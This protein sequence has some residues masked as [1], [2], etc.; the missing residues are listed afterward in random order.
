MAAFQ[1]HPLHKACS[2]GD[3]SRVAEL[4]HRKGQ[5]WKRWDEI[6]GGVTPLHVAAE[7]NYHEVCACLLAAGAKAE[8][9]DG[10]GFTPAFYAARRN[11]C[12]ALEALRLGGADFEL[13]VQRVIFSS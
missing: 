12:E 8:S 3:L 7:Q 11:N 5:Y 13:E 4:V 1:H 6:Y 9:T 10:A 2:E